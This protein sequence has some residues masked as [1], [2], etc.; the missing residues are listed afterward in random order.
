MLE[1]WYSGDLEEIW[2]GIIVKSSSSVTRRDCILSTKFESLL[3]ERR[4]LI[5]QKT[6]TECVS[7]LLA[8]FKEDHEKI[9][10]RIASIRASR[11]VTEAPE[12]NLDIKDTK[13]Q[14]FMNPGPSNNFEVS[15]KSELETPTAVKRYKEISNLARPM[16]DAFHR[17][18]QASDPTLKKAKLQ[19]RMNINKRI[20]QIA[21]SRAH[22]KSI[23]NELTF[24]INEAWNQHGADFMNYCIV[25]TAKKIVE[26]A[27]T[28][29]SLHSP[30]AFPVAQVVVDLSC[31]QKGLMPVIVYLIMKKCPYAVPRYISRRVDQSVREHKIKMGYTE[32]GQSL[33]QEMMYTE[34]MAGIL[35]L[36]GA[37]IQSKPTSGNSLLLLP[38]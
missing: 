21:N 22:I 32:N 36:Y 19:M 31:Q 28:Q 37:I 24:I 12:P 13:P 16:L 18:E 6:L 27:E 20:I 11:R 29:I 33:E 23:V 38:L 25:I 30:S 15:E 7:G 1:K 17:L 9:L 3:S 26:Q 35:C 10:S 8:S 14:A 2:K 34:R 4:E 5:R